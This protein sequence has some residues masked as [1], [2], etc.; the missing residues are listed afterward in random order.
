MRAATTW[1]GHAGLGR[2][3]QIGRPRYAAFAPRRDDARLVD[4]ELRLSGTAQCHNAAQNFTHQLHLL[5]SDQD[6]LLIP[7]NRNYPRRLTAQWSNQAFS[8]RFRVPLN[9]NGRQL[10][11]VGRR[12]RG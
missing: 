5:R 11:M 4:V 2:P 8:S 1:H 9:L 12:G 3:S 7:I 10:S 6:P